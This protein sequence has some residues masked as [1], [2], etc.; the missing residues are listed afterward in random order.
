MCVPNTH[1]II[2]EN[3]YCNITPNGKNLAA[4]NKIN[5]NI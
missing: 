4:I 2:H 1:R 3:V 5:E